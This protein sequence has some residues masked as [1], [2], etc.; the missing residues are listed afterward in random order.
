[1]KI[2]A[3]LLALT[4]CVGMN[5]PAVPAAADGEEY[6][7]I[8]I[9]D[10]KQ[11]WYRIASTG[12]RTYYIDG[13]KARGLTEIEGRLFYFDENGVMLTDTWQK[14]GGDSYYFGKKGYALSGRQIIDGTDYIFGSDCILLR[15][16]RRTNI[17]KTSPAPYTYDDMSEDIEK[18]AK[19][20][21]EL[22]EYGIIGVTADSR[23]IYD[24]VMGD[25]GADKQ[26]VIQA[27]CHAREYMT[28]LLVMEQL[29]YCLN[30]YYTDEY[31]GVLFKDLFDEYAIHIVPM[32][33]PDGVTI[34]QLGIDGINDETIREALPEMYENA[35]E[36]GYTDYTEERYYQRW[37]A[38]ALGVDLNNN[39]NGRWETLNGAESPAGWSY[40]GEY[41]ES[42]A[43][44]AAITSLI[45]GLSN[46][47]TV[48]SYHATGSV[49]W[50]DYG[51]TGE[52]M[53]RCTEQAELISSLTG[54]PLNPYSK[55]SAG[56]LSDW[57]IAE[58]YGDIVPETIEIGKG[59]AP[60]KMSEYRDIWK[61]NK[62]VI[63]ALAYL[64]E[65]GET[66]E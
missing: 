17:V 52:F 51:Q 39:F 21:P 48:V 10:T 3:I 57:I 1:M 23:N 28:S 60:M 42:E 6:Y 55:S 29:E 40:K 24:I 49:L 54:Y 2:R 8:E 35:V 47:L 14:L 41:P 18:L 43:E 45:R 65:Y 27:S 31:N 44:S 16:N 58:Y 25:P 32:L 59:E 15:E 46:P 5:I 7:E 30:G 36:N 66:E 13:E 19:R 22:I 26:I 63:P 37:K 64:Y 4:V 9:D 12:E 53:E 62:D 38:N 61:R 34:S 11:G 56:G 50:W 20:Y 33:N